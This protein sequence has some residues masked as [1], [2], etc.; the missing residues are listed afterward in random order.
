MTRTYLVVWWM[1]Q[2]PYAARFENRISAEAAAK[3]RNALMVT[4]EGG[5]ASVVDWYRRNDAGE[6]ML[7]EWRD[8]VVM[9]HAPAPG[10][11]VHA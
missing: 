6:P 5:V 3:V 10:G 9:P 4:V 11:R 8:V 7:A 1:Q 2:A